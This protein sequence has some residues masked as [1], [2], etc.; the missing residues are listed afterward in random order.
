MIA[1]Y[2]YD[3]FNF[4]FWGAVHLSLFPFVTSLKVKDDLVTD[5]EKLFFVAFIP[6]LP[7][8]CP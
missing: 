4:I 2:H 6:F 1:I 3:V 7:E 8:I 5:E